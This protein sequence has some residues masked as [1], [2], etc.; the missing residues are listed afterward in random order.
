[1]SQ[2]DKQS[3]SNRAKVETL[4]AKVE[5]NAKSESTVEALKREIR[6]Y[7]ESIQYLQSLLDALSVCTRQVG[8]VAT[9]IN[10]VL[11]VHI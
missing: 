2:L 6:E 5:A 11:G 4:E 8:P 10:A 1:M 3:K 7:S 9:Q